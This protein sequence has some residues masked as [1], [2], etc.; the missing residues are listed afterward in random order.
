AAPAAGSRVRRSGQATRRSRPSFLR[1]AHEA[2]FRFVD[3]LAHVGTVLQHQLVPLRRARLALR[4]L[5]SDRRLVVRELDDA[6]ALQLEAVAALDQR[7][8]VAQAAL[9]L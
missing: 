4:E 2:L 1:P 9:E 8:Q 3:A 6:H 5:R 7:P